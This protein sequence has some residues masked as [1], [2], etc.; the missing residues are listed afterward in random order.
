MTERKKVRENEK[1]PVTLSAADRALVLDHT[2][3]DPDLTAPLRRLRRRAEDVIV[4]YTLSDL[5][6]LQ[7]FIAAE[8]NHTKDKKRQKRL[9]ALHH[10]LQN[11]M[12]RYDDGLWQEPQT[13]ATPAARVTSFK[14]ERA[15]RAGASS[16]KPFHLT[17]ALTPFGRS[18]RRR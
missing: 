17:P 11:E 14:K 15:T 18:D 4:R 1:V 2:F 3:A 8:A 7:G 12:E 9:D 5:E 10:R 16:N 6:K 13:K